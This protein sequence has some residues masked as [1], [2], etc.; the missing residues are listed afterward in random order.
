MVGETALGNFTLVTAGQSFTTDTSYI[1]GVAVAWS[2]I[3]GDLLLGDYSTTVTFDVPGTW[4][5]D[6][7]SSDGTNL[8][9]SYTVLTVAESLGADEGVSLYQ[10]IHDVADGS[11]DLTEATASSDSAD[12]LTFTSV[13]DLLDEDDYW[14]G[15]EAYFLDGDN[16]GTHRRV[17]GSDYETQTITVTPALPASILSGDRVE[18]YNKR[19]GGLRR[20]KYKSLINRAIR[21]ISGNFMVKSEVT[22]SS[23]DGSIL[24][25]V[26]LDSVC[27]VYYFDTSSESW[28]DIKR[29]TRPGAKGWWPDR[30][31]NS[32]GMSDYWATGLTNYDLKIVGYTTPSALVYDTDRTNVDPE[33]IVETCIGMAQM[34]NP[35]NYQNLGPGQYFRNRGDS[36]RSKAVMVTESNCARIR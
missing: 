28:R 9:Y 10:L 20:I 32:I 17:L 27:R 24:L 11:Q 26:D 29:A 22:E 35:G 6:G 3:F 5:W 36:I 23:Y 2:P 33:W 4:V 31:A 7:H 12:L 16:A 1:N 14:R 19:D 18:L 8:H 13:Q 25:P 30:G 21:D 34:S 15:G